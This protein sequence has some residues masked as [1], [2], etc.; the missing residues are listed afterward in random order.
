ME[1][2]R[3]LGMNPKKLPGLRPSPQQGWKLPVGAFIEE[4]YRKQFGGAPASDNSRSPK[5]ERRL[6]AD[7]R[8]G[9]APG[10]TAQ[11]ENLVCYF[12]NLSEDLAQW[13]VYGKPAPEVLVQ[14]REELR[15]IADKLEAGE[16]V[17][18]MPGIANPPTHRSEQSANRG[19]QEHTYDGDDD[20]PF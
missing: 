12:A 4:C 2:A 1:M 19:G 7:S 18:Q 16:R 15:A 8:S 13:L 20:I 14:V 17:P 6:T 3:A 5:G 10:L 9:T 11:I